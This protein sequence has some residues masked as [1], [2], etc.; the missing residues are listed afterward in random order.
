MGVWRYKIEQDVEIEI[1]DLKNIYFENKWIKISNS[2]IIIR[3]QYAWDGCS[4]AYCI[5]LGTSLPNGLWLG[6]WDGPKAQDGLPVTWLASLVHDALCQFRKDICGLSKKKTVLI[7]KKLLI[8]RKAPGYI[9][10]LYPTAIDLFG[11]QEWY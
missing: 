2:K 11:P 1:T 5:R 6:V 9:T 3:A 4:P 8:E 7:F 10:F